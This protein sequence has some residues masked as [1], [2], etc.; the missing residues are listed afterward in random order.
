MIPLDRL[1]VGT[2]ALGAA[3]LAFGASVAAWV[4]YAML[5]RALRQRIGPHGPRGAATERIWLAAA[6]A[7]GIGAFLHWALPDAHPAILAVETLLP[8]GVAYLAGAALLG[9]RFAWRRSRDA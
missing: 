1:G 9:E 5:R 4:E 6:V 7:G 2:L 8:F 3:G